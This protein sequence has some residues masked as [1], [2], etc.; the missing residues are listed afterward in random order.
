LPREVVSILD[1]EC[2]FMGGIHTV[3]CTIC[4]H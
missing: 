4:G 1:K 3:C 2:V